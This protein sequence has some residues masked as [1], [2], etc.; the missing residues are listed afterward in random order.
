[1]VEVKYQVHSRLPRLDENPQP[2][3]RVKDPLSMFPRY[4]AT[5]SI[6]TWPVPH[7]DLFSHGFL[8]SKLSSSR[9]PKLEEATTSSTVTTTSWV[10]MVRGQRFRSLNPLL[11]CF[12]LPLMSDSQACCPPRHSAEWRLTFQQ[13]PKIPTLEYQGT[14]LGVEARMPE[15]IPGA[16]DWPAN[17]GARV[18]V[19]FLPV[20]EKSNLGQRR[21][22]LGEGSG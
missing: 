5:P 15:V 20:L 19:A 12:Y 6:Q 22:C 18:T 16:R 10:L 14:W 21:G 1:M 4:F 11:P 9:C 3:V 8:C 13:M 7:F 17:R 2:H